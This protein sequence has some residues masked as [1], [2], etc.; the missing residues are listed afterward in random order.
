LIGTLLVATCYIAINIAFLYVVPINELK[1][2]IEIGSI[3]GKYLF[4]PYGT[5]LI[6]IMISILL[7]STVSAYIFL[8]P[9][10]TQEMIKDMPALNFLKDKNTAKNS[11][12]HRSFA[13]SAVLALFFILSGT[14]DQVLVYTSFLLI[15]ITTLTVGGL[16][17]LRLNKKYPKAPYQAWG[18][19]IMP[20]FFIITN[21]WVLYYIFKERPYESLIGSGILLLGICVFYFTLPRNNAIG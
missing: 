15:L 20:L 10:V 16:F 4:G 5:Q 19:P 2:Q 13:F 14:F 11:T 3:A 18:Y 8:G 21:V 6:A 1:G 9:R 17:I 7:L 12:T